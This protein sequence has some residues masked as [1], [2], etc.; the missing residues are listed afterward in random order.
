MAE[1]LDDEKRGGKYAINYQLF[2]EAIIFS[3]NFEVTEE[4]SRSK[5]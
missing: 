5:D 4:T 2:G 1:I 3:L